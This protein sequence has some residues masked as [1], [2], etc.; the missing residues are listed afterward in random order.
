[1]PTPTRGPSSNAPRSIVSIAERSRHLAI[2]SKIQ[3]GHPLTQSEM[4]ELRKYEGVATAPRRH[5][6]GYDDRK[7]HA[8][9]MNRRR[10]AARVVEIPEPADPSRRQK[11]LADPERFCRTYWPN[12]FYNPFARNQ[13]AIIQAIVDRIGVG[14]NLSLALP[15]AE[16]KTSLTICIGGVWGVVSGKVFY[17]VILTANGEFAEYTLSDLKSM[18]ELSDT[19]A[20][21]FP[22]ICC[23]VRAL[24]G[25]PQRARAQTARPAGGKFEPERTRLVWATK[26]VVLPTVRLSDGTMALTSGV[27][28]VT[29]GADGAIRGLVRS[30][31]R[32]DLVIGDDLETQ[33]SAY[34]KKQIDDRKRLLHRDVMGLSGPTTPM[35]I[36][37]LG[38]IITSGCLMDQLTDRSQNP[39]WGGI[40]LRRILQYPKRMDLWDKYIEQ[41]KAD[42]RDGDKAARNA[43]RFYLTNRV[44]MDEGAEVSNPYRIR[45]VKLPDGSILEASA[46]QGC[47]NDL[48]DMGQEGFDAEHQS[49]PHKDDREESTAILPVTVQRKINR[50]PKGFIPE[51]TEAIT[52][53]I[54]VGSR[55]LHWVAIAWRR[56]MMGSI[57]DYGTEPVHSPLTENLKSD[58]Q[59]QAVRRA[60]FESLI[61]FREWE[62][63]TGWQVQGN[64]QVRHADLINIDAGY[65][66]TAIYDFLCSG[67]GRGCY[68]VRGY[69]ST[70][71]GSYPRPGTAKQKRIGNH[72]WASWHGAD[73]V[74]IHHVDSDHWKLHVQTGFLIKDGVDGGLSLFGDNPVVHT[75]YAKQICAERWLE[76]FV[77]GKG[78]RRYFRLEHRHNHFLDATHY[79]TVGADMMGLGVGK[80]PPAPPATN[81]NSAGM[82]P[83]TSIRTS[84]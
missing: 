51:G 64:N 62:T 83:R 72:W 54:D 2:L 28:I 18:Y 25:S 31:R 74:W 57:F 59:T 45:A 32:P 13:T 50:V 84:Y 48:C 34:S 47:F 60:I 82:M 58:E 6:A 80:P 14:G 12:I 23:P 36:L 24:E 4:R 17:L 19:F 41:R 49:A 8:E 27:I 1:M 15:R 26:S 55:L 9:L 65:M 21:D 22:E 77:P 3:R 7:S 69:G 75:N 70:Q 29:K 39:A 10:A 78:I 33:E 38:S 35:P 61:Q 73:K 5:P 42:Q 53:G 66:D 11:C 44:E 71:R 43:H 37:I 52:I 81:Q 56:G 30:G 68:A 67:Q 16:G 63:G 79:A 76:E 20:A 40:R 46:L